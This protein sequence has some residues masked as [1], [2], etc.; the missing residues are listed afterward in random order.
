MTTVKEILN[1]MDEIA[2][3]STAEAYDNVG[4]IAGDHSAMVKKVGFA[5]DL[6]LEIAE[7][8]TMQQVDLIITHHPAIFTPIKHLYADHPVF[9]VIRNGINLIAAHTNLDK[10][11]KGV[12]D[13][14]ANY[15]Q[16]VTVTTPESLD[17]CGK[18][19]ELP[20][21]MAVPAYVEL[22]KTAVGA[23]RIRYYDSGKPVKSVCYVPGSGGEYLLAAQACGAD[24]F[25][26][27][28]IKH[29]VFVDAQ[30]LGLNLIEVS[31]YDAEVTILPAL[32]EQFAV[33]FPQ[34]ET[35]LLEERKIRAL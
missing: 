23:E 4:L 35:V 25:I 6:T 17:G 19:G 8:A 9:Q 15:Y 21:A 28:D 34:I 13:V 33:R 12:A 5:L 7:K 2:P 14:L 18:L 30:N 22:L 11:E 24:T 29:N 1:W 3:F 10:A 31:H 26:T 32:Q 16:L 27:G 20:T